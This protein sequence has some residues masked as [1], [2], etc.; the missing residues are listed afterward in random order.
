MA[1]TITAAAVREMLA[2]NSAEVF[3]VLLTFSHPSI[4][5]LR[6]VNNT[7]DVISRGNTYVAFPFD[8]TLP[9][10]VADRMVSVQLSIN[11]VDRRLIDEIRAVSEPITVTLEIIA[12]SAPNTVEVGPFSFTMVSADY[13]QETITASLTYEPV[14]SEPFPARSFDPRDFPGLFGRVE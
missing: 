14:L 8:I 1:R 9:N 6:L 7:Q 12:A 2:Q 3:L 4:A 13:N 11:N 5:A 10:D